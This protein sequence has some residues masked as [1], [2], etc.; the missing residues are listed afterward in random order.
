MLKNRGL[1]LIWKGIKK[2]AVEYQALPTATEKAQFAMEKFGRLAGP[3]M[4]KILEKTTDE[5]DKMVK[6]L[7]GSS[8][9]MGTSGPGS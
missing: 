6:E 3:E 9:I 4:Q 8:L 7:E 1:L 2:L 5:I